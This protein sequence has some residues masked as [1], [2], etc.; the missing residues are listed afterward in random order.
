MDIHDAGESGVERSGDRPKRTPSK[1]RDAV[2]FAR[3][4]R[5]SGENRDMKI[6]VAVRKLVTSEIDDAAE[7]EATAKR[8]LAADFLSG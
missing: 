4:A 3:R 7:V 8:L 6:A 5:N 1:R 2:L